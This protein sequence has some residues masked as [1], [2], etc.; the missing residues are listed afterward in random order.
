MPAERLPMRKI[1]EVLRL[2][3]NLALNERATARACKVARSTVRLYVQ[4]ARD[5]GLERWK[6]IEALGDAELEKALFPPAP[7]PS[8]R[9]VMPNWGDVHLELQK[10]N[11]TRLQVWSEYKASHPDG[12]EYSRFCDLY[13]EF[14]GRMDLSMR[15]VHRAGE[16]MFVDYCGQTMP[17]KDPETGEIREAQI[18]V[19]VLGA[20]NYTFAEAT[21]SQQL[22]DWIGSHRRAFAYYGGTPEIVVPDNLR[23]AVSKA[24][25]YDPALNPTYQHLADH[26]GV[27]VIPARVRKPKDKAKVETGVQVVERWILAALRNWEFLSLD[28]LNRKIGELLERLNHRPFRKLDGT[29]RS[30]FEALDRPAMGP[31]PPGEFQYSD[32]ARGRVDETYHVYVDDHYYS[33]PYHLVGHELEARLGADSVEFLHGSRRVACHVRSREKGGATTLPEHMPESHRRYAESSPERLLDWARTIAEPV[34]K[35]VSSILNDGRHPIQSLRA[36]EGVRAL[37]KHHGT[38]RLVAACE[39]ALRIGSTS[40]TTLRSILSLGQERLPLPGDSDVPALPGDV[41]AEN[42]RGASYFAGSDGT[43]AVEEVAPC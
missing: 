38:E 40:L 12:L 16:K 26:Y 14:Q 33:V 22:P 39:R 17:V 28:E 25:R 7:R 31:L 20:S 8:G 4:R 27:A 43:S 19:S 18:F 42:V 10:K 6:S 1:R 30:R 5:A 3:W 37:E 24:C 13:R 15:Q 34:V 2:R 21:W 11:V 23:S 9:R 35:V 29:R 36:A 32:W 41:G